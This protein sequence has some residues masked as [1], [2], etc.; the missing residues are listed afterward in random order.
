MLSA[1]GSAPSVATSHV[2][3]GITLQ[4]VVQTLFSVQKSVTALHESVEK[5]HATQARIEINLQETKAMQA[6]ML[7]R[8]R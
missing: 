5:V 2:V 7:K 8:I 6:N 3:S 4:D 1:A